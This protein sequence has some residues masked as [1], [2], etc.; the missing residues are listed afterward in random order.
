[1]ARGTRRARG[2]E[3][4]PFHGRAGNPMASET[5]RRAHR[6]RRSL[7]RPGGGDHASGRRSESGAGLPRRGRVRSRAGLDPTR[8]RG[9]RD[10]RRRAARPALPRIFLERRPGGSRVRA[11]GRGLPDALDGRA[12]G[13]ADADPLGG[14]SAGDAA[15]RNEAGRRF[16][17]RAC[18]SSGACSESP[19]RAR[20]GFSSRP[21]ATTGPPIRSRA[22]RTAI[23]PSEAPTR[24]T[25]SPGRSAARSSSRG[26]RRRRMRAAPFPERS[27]AAAA[28]R[29][30]RSRRS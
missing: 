16:S 10:G 18:A 22:A 4:P 20:G 6:V 13:P 8:A 19:R 28:P 2:R 12:G 29:G 25:A 24:P 9:R 5:G 23:R 11:R 26:K 21:T 14:R 17:T 30:R 7:S 27:R 1:M 3:D 15:P